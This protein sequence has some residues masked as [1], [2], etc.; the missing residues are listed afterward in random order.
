[1][2]WE[3]VIRACLCGNNNNNENSNNKN[4][5]QQQRRVATIKIHNEV[6]TTIKTN[7]NNNENS[8]C[9]GNNNNDIYVVVIVTYF[10]IFIYKPRSAHR[11]L[12][13]AWNPC[14]INTKPAPHWHKCGSYLCYDAC[15]CVCVCVCRLIAVLWVAVVGGLYF[16]HHRHHNILIILHASVTA[17]SI[18]IAVLVCYCC[19]CC[20]YCF[21]C[22]HCY[23]AQL[24]RK[25]TLFS[26]FLLAA[27][28]HRCSVNRWRRLPK[29]RQQ[30]S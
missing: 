12:A 14:N 24:L 27:G 29:I 15:M 7:I 19:C 8:A 25:H 3:W 21:I 16:C 30:T 11:A 2:Q 18:A 26:Q 5:V 1:M 10:H 6:R 22:L 13:D 20:F 9:N 28:K 17:S 4:I 23:Y